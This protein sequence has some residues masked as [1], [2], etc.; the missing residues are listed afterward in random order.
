M[1]AKG[2]AAKAKAPGAAARALARALVA[3]GVVTAA[4]GAHV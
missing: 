1:A 3:K 4:F 2:V